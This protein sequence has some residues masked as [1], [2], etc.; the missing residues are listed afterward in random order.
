MVEQLTSRTAR[1]VG[2]TDRG[3]VAEGM[4]ADLNVIDMD[5]LKLFSPS[6]DYDLPA[7]GKRLTQRAEGYVATYVSGVAVRRDGQ[8]TGARPGQ[9]VRG[10]GV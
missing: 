8:D 3:V 9:L 5:R 6:V 4:K 7:G 10:A 1:T 2:L